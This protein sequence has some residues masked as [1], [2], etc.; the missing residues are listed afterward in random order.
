[1]TVI[2]KAVI[3][4]YDDDAHKATVQIAGS[5][6][7][8]LESVRV[9]TDIPA[10]DV[11]VGRQCA[12]L[13][14][15]PSNQDDAVV[16]TIQGALPSAG[17]ILKAKATAN[18]TLTTAAQSITGDGDSGK[19]RLLLDAGTWFIT[20]T[21]DFRIT[22]SGVDTCVGELFVNDSGTPEAS[23]ALLSSEPRATVSQ[24]WRVVITVNDT[25]V[26]LKAR[27]IA[28]GGTA[29]CVATHTTIAAVAALPPS[30]GGGGTTFIAL[31]DTPDSYSGQA[32]KLVRVNAGAAALEFYDHEGAANPHAIYLTQ[33]EADALYEALGVVAAHGPSKHTTGAAWKLVYQDA[34]GDEQEIAL[35][36]DGQVLTS[37]GAASAPAFETPAG[38]GGSSHAPLGGLYPGVLSTG[39]KPP[40]VPY[41]GAAFTIHKLYCRVTTPPQSQAITVQ[42]RRNGASMGTVTIAAAANTGET[43]VDVAVSS[44]DYF[45]IDIT[46]VGT[47]PNQGSDLVWLVVP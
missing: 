40:Q 4:S 24:T 22:V 47:S 39:V 36:T 21:F 44:G 42:I 12:V 14:L 11:V 18:L 3:K 30:G 28:A 31:T 25:P 41:R 6:G 5:L 10:A 34:N 15:D 8:W 9:A 27:K 19:V 37:T 35:G 16:I 46:Q 33:A 45:D 7:V 1:M 26:E 43:D 2:K 13:F 23:Q 20:G 29:L 17:A 32:L 38:G